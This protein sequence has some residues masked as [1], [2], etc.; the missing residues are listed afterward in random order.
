MKLQESRQKIDAINKQMIR[1]FEERLNIVVEIA[2]YKE[3]H[4]MQIHDVEREQEILEAAAQALTNPELGDYAK[5]FMGEV[6][7]ICKEYEKNHIHQHIFLIGMPG[8]GKTT[9]GKALAQALGL[10]FFDVDTEIQERTGKSIQN[11]IIHDGEDDFHKLEFEVI[12]D[13]VSHKKASV[14]ATGGGT[15]LFDETVALMRESGYVVLIQRD[16]KQILDDLDME[17]RPL[18][19]ESIEYIFRLYEERQP[20]YER[21]SH[22]KIENI[23]NVADVVQAVIAAL[24]NAS[25]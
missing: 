10:E 9:I 25:L 23:S 24:P 11:I 8:A 2:K 22:I 1:L 7:R 18:L 4:Q 5:E 21:V 15:V 16:V 17:I 12:Q 3:E 14:I 19:K 6:M 20:I 13:L